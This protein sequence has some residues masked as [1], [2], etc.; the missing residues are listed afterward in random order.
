[1]PNKK[2]VIKPNKGQAVQKYDYGTDVG[3]GFENQTS[4]DV[5]MPFINV[6]QALSP[7]LE[8]IPGA[9][10]G[11]LF[12]NTTDDLYPDGLDFVPAITE[13]CYI[14][15][16]PRDAGGG[17][18]ARYEITDPAV[19]KAKQESTEF[20]KLSV[21]DHDLVETYN[22][23]CV[24]CEGPN[25][26]DMFMLSFTSSKIKVYKK[27]NSRWNRFQVLGPGNIKVTPPLFGHATRLT[28]F[29]DK[30]KVGQEFYNFTLAPTG[31]DMQA[32]LLPPDDPRYIKARELRDLYKQGVLRPDFDS[33][34]ADTPDDAG[35]TRADGKPVF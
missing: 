8:T 13:H 3:G 1:M 34:K 5:V 15:W 10:V 31:T 6:L 2:A 7:Q 21:G 26:V 12:N 20:G 33:A 32:S 4:E 9:K 24:L 23:Y 17:F 27:Y 35:P 16:I 25:P 19:L 28:T 22:V 30:N 14:E 18:I 11:T 29:K